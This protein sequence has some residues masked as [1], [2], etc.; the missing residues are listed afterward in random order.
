LN[1][2]SSSFPFRFTLKNLG[3][4]STEVDFAGH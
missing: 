3:N 2:N 1:P 4:D